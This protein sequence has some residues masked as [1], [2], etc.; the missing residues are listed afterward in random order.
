[1]SEA[2]RLYSRREC[3]YHEL[4]GVHITQLKDIRRSPLH[5]RHHLQHGR[6]SSP[7]LELGTAGHVAVLEPE[8][9]LLDFALWKSEH[10]DGTK[11][12]R[13]GKLWDEFQAQNAGKTIIRDEEYDIAIALRDAVRA[14]SVAMRYLAMGRPE[15]AMTWTDSHTGVACVG[16]IDWET[17]VDGHPAIVDLKTTRNAG[18]TWFSRDVAK[19]D[20]HLQLA[21]YAD[22]YEAATGKAPRVVVVAVE[23]APP[24][25]VVTYIVPA[26]VLDI[27]RDQYRQLLEGFRDCTAANDWPGQGRGVEQVLALPAWAVPDDD[28]TADLG[29]V[30]WK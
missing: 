4:P 2:A 22:G 6:E 25:D 17:K 27:G 24:H 12:V 23:S 26:D 11:R 13:R 8:R 1:M 14:D 28:D 15:V 5:Y 20:Y 19:L 7:S 30:G 3:R 18:P 21:F 10:D 29:L 9:F 16:R